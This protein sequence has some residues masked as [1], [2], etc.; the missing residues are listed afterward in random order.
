MELEGL[1]LVFLLIFGV[2]IVAVTMYLVNFKV[3]NQKS[4][5]IRIPAKVL[6]S[7]LE[8]ALGMSSLTVLFDCENG[9]RIRLI[10]AGDPG[11]VSG[12]SGILTYRGRQFI[13]F[14][15]NGDQI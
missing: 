5:E 4:L 15:M 13:S 10:I 3:S 7:R 14:E 2:S 1:V 9:D 6:E 8:S 11:Y 12:D